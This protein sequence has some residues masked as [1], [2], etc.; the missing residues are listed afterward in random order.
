MLVDLRVLVTLRQTILVP[1]VVHEQ[2]QKPLQIST[3]VVETMQT[4]R[5]QEI[6]PV[7]ERYLPIFQATML[8]LDHIR[9]LTL[10]LMP[11]VAPHPETS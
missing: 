11:V 8:V 4:I 10:E 5:M 6:M 2:S 7:H 9:R 3:L 1:M